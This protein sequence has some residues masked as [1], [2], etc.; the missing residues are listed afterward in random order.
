MIA[1]FYGTSLPTEVDRVDTIEA[2]NAASLLVPELQ[3]TGFAGLATELGNRL[4]RGEKIEPGPGDPLAAIRQGESLRDQLGHYLSGTFYFEGEWY[5]SVDRIY[6]LEA[7][8]TALGLSLRHD[9]GL[10]VPR[11][12]P[13][14]C[15]GLDTT[16]IT[17]EF[18]PSLRSPYSAIS[19]ARTIDLVKR[20]GVALKLKPV[21]PMM[22]RGVPA[23]RHK[24][25]YIIT[26]TKREAN[27]AGVRFG[28]I[29][30]PFGE[31]VKRAFSLLPS[32]QALG[33]EV[34]YCGAYLRGAWEEGIDITTDD[35]L[36]QVVEAAGIAWPDV[37]DHLGKPGWESLLDGNVQEML[38]FGL[39]GVPSFRVTGGNDD[40][41]FQ[42]WG[43]DRLWRVE[44]E[45]ARRAR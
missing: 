6:H 42:C 4:W 14:T 25:I 2:T 37:V 26:D 18:F 24:Q 39:W 41:P 11:P 10:C 31:P 13:E 23:P 20:T 33:K 30:D 17:L 8:L 35:G 22:M 34:E 3:S 40:A 21:M 27:A 16:D 12:T 5:W 15:E 29:V 38:D 44:T 45:I 43:Q 7:R 32:I 1:P 36:R 9:R 28:N 19:Y